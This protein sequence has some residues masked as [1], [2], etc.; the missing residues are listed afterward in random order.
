M[1]KRHLGNKN[2]RIIVELLRFQF[3]IMKFKFPNLKSLVLKNCQIIK[4]RTRDRDRKRA[5]S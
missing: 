4:S 5:L 1:L 2:F 3:E